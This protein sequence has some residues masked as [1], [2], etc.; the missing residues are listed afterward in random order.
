MVPLASFNKTPA[1][2]VSLID[3][4]RLEY[5]IE[6]KRQEVKNPKITGDRFEKSLQQSQAVFS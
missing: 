1:G 5:S 6:A 3:K 4:K 2:G